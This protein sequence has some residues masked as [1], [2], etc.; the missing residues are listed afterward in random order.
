MRLIDADAFTKWWRE[1]YCDKCKRK[2]TI[3]CV[4]CVDDHFLKCLEKYA[5]TIDAE[6][7]RH[8][9]WVHTD[10]TDHFSLE[11]SV[12]GFGFTDTKLTYCYDCGAL[13]DEV[14]E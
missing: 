4:G 7:V 8:G 10:K 6:P 3:D 13:M 11:C 9:H 12:C 1:T 2:K 14:T 5:P